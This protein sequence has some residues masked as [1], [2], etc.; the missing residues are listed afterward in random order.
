[1]VH[2]RGQRQ[3]AVGEADTA[4]Q[5]HVAL[6]EV[7]A[8][9]PDM[10]ARPRGLGEGDAIAI[11]H[12]IFLDHDGVG[13]LGD[14]AAGEDPHRLAGP[15]RLVER[16]AGRDLADHLQMRPRGGGIRGAHRIAVHRR[17]R[18]RRLGAQG[19][20]VARQHA[21][22]GRVQ[23]GHFLRQWLGARENGC[24]RLGNRH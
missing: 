22:K 18:L 20:H 23:R 2:A 11:G 15:Q 6:A 12:G 10:P 3:I 21:V 8:G 16:P 19:R 1:M 7:D 4:R 5:Q 14:H 17:H 9:G 24:K 13:A